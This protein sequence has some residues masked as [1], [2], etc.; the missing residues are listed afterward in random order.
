MKREICLAV[1]LVLAFLLPGNATAY[2]QYNRVVKFD[3]YFS[4]YSKRFFGPAFDW[5]YFKGQAVAE[6]RLKPEAKSKV[7]ARGLMQIMPRTFEEI[8]RRSHTVKGN[9]KQ[10]RWNIAAGIYY[11]RM[12][13]NGFKARRPFKDRVNF[14]F[15]AY[16]A[17]KR[18][19]LRAQKIARKQKI[20]ENLWRSVE[21]CLPRVTGRRSKETINYVKKINAI[22]EVLR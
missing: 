17:G 22:K 20:N 12:L 3:R 9:W 2:E 7:G 21:K 8:K 6:S 1:L 4:K 16:N 18:N 13:W 10:P 11:D 19:I 5:R 15:G 14:M